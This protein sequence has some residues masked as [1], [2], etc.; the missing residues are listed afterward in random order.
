METEQKINEVKKCGKPAIGKLQYIKILKG[1]KV[2]SEDM[3]ASMCYDC[4]G[5][6]VDG[7]E[8][9]MCKTCPLYSKMPYRGTHLKEELYMENL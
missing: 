9:C 8:D 2:S 7:S 3:M 4:M 5:Y 6:Y 1:K